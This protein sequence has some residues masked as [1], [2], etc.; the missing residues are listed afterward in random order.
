MV[1]HYPTKFS[2]H[3][4]CGSGDITSSVVK[5]QDSP[6]SLNDTH[7]EKIQEQFNTRTGKNRIL[8]ASDYCSYNRSK[9]QRFYNSIKS[10]GVYER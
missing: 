3:R 6:C 7:R 2:S 8:V 4:H 10:T 9:F 1:S 5:E